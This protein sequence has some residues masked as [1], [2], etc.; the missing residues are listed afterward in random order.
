MWKL[1]VD[2]SQLGGGGAAGLLTFG[3]RLGYGCTCPSGHVARKT[4]SVGAGV[5]GCLR[6]KNEALV[7]DEAFSAEK[8]P[9]SQPVT[10]LAAIVTPLTRDKLKKQKSSVEAALRGISG[11]AATEAGSL[12]NG[13]RTA[14]AE[15]R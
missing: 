6:D 8:V 2:G 11:T 14:A 1:R 7:L 3:R 5:R 15:R 12:G 4:G 10:Q 13:K 9:L